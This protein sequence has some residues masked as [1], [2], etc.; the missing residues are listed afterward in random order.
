MQHPKLSEKARV[1]PITDAKSYKGPQRSP[2]SAS[3]LLPQ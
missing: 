3:Q 1:S 2:K